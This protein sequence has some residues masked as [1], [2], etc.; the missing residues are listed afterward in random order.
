MYDFV[1]FI[2]DF[3]KLPPLHEIGRAFI[4]MP[5]D[6]GF[7]KVD[8]KMRAKAMKNIVGTGAHAPEWYKR[9]AEKL[10]KISARRK[11]HDAR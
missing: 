2:E 5:G 10:K 6:E 1:A 8:S 11:P 7:K 9:G 4:L 3:K